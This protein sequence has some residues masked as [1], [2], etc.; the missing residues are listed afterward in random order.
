V[1][2]PA[3]PPVGRFDRDTAVWRESSSGSQSVFA[4][5][6]SPDWRAGRGPHGGYLAAIL[7]RALTES[8]ADAARAPRSLTIH[9]TR[10]PEPGPIEIRTV[11]EREGRSLS[12]LSARMEQGGV[13]MALALAAFSVP[14]SGP[15]IADLEM[16]RVAPPDLA[17]GGQ[18]PH[19]Q[20]P[21]IASRSTLHPRFGGVPFSGEEQPMVL[22]GWLGHEEPRAIDALSLAFFSDA[23]LPGPFMRLTEPNAAPTIDL[24]IHFRSALPHPGALSDDE[25]RG[26]CL[27]RITTGLVQEGFFEEDGLI[28]DADGTVLS[29]SRQLAL[30]L[31][32][33]IG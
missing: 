25:G 9:Y 27:A 2:D 14:W 6:V 31:P 15:Q 33:S 24:T 26:L 7:L 16:P 11:I 8:V 13:L 1:A 18:A 3:A 17:A 22:G 28:W 21:P 30:L 20:A 12:T 5:Q 29:Q 32:M 19:P 4:A 23:L 10:A